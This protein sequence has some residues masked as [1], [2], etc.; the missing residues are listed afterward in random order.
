MKTLLFASALLLSAAGADGS[1][2]GAPASDPDPN[3]NDAGQAPEPELTEEEIKTLA[4]RG[5]DAQADADYQELFAARREKF[6]RIRRETPVQEIELKSCRGTTKLGAVIARPAGFQCLALSDQ[7]VD[8]VVL[9]AGDTLQIFVLAGEGIEAWEFYRGQERRANEPTPATPV[10]PLE[11]T[12]PT[13]VISQAD[14]DADEA[15]SISSGAGNHSLGSDSAAAQ[16][17]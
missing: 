12:Q 9:H 4:E 7:R 15:C 2:G 11:E 10:D 17:S 14:K 8:R 1:A 5:I 6:E 3:V 16:G 13:P